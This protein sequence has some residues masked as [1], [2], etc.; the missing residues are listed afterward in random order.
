MA[1]PARSGPS[2]QGEAGQARGLMIQFRTGP[3][4][5]GG[6][7]PLVRI[8]LSRGKPAGYRGAI[9]EAVYTA[10]VK[11]LDAPEDEAR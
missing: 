5:L 3:G 4:R 9:V 7:M 6:T 10:M 2:P 1:W 11:A 8:D